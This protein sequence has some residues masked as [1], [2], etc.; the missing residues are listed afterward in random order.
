M[1]TPAAGGERIA[2]FEVLAAWTIVWAIA[3]GVIAAAS[4]LAA[5]LDGGGSSGSPQ[6]HAARTGDSR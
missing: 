3:G 4:P 6:A 1:N 2:W 5:V